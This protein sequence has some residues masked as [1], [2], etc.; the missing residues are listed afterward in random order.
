MTGGTQITRTRGSHAVLAHPISIV[1]QMA[2]R[3]R[4]LAL[5]VDVATVAV[6]RRPLVLVLVTSKARRHL[7][8]K[9]LGAFEADLDVTSHAVS[10]RRRHVRAMI[11]TQMLSRHLGARPHVVFAMAAIARA[12]VV[13]LGVAFDAVFGRGKVHLLITFRAHHAGVA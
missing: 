2:R 12:R 9:A 4:A 6:A 8:T 11:E 13:R 3:K 5:H 7:R 10:L 1:H